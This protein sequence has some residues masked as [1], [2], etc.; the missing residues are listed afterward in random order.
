MLNKADILEKLKSILVSMDKNNASIVDKIT[1]NTKLVTDLGLNSIGT[2]Y[3]VIAIEE[4][5]KIEFDND[6]PFS[7]VGEVVDFIEAKTR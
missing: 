6:K 3:M 5:F 4:T 1:Y 7:T 2:L